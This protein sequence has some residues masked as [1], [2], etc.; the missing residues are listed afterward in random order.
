MNEPPSRK[1]ILP[2][3]SRRDLHPENVAYVEALYAQYH[4]D[5]TLIPAPWVDYFAAIEQSTAE[6]SVTPGGG[7]TPCTS[8]DLQLERLQVRVLQY[9]NSY[10]FLG[11]FGAYLDPLGRVKPELP[12]ELTR[13]YHQLDRVSSSQLFDPGSLHA[14]KP[15]NLDQIEAILRD[16]YCACIGPE[17]MHLTSTTEK[18]WIQQRL[19]SARGHFGFDRATRLHILER[20]TAA[21]G[22]ERYLHTRYVGQKRFSL[23]GAESLIPLLNALVQRGGSRGLREIVLG[24]AH[25]GRLNVQVNLFGKSLQEL[26][27]EF[28]GRHSHTRGT[29]DVKYHL[30]LS[31]DVDTRGGRVH[32][33]LAFN[34]SHLE[35]VAPVVV[36]SVR[37]RQVRA[38]DRQGL[39]ILPVVVHGDAAFA[40]Q[41]VVMETLNMSQTR[42][43]STKGTVHIVVNNQ[44]GFTTSTLKDAR[45]THYS[46]DVAKM[47]SAPIFHVNA[48]DPEAVV[49]IT[50]IA[51][52]YRMR[53]AKDVVIDL[54]CYRRHG[55]NE[56]DEPA[57][58]QPMMYRRIRALP[59]TRERYA[60]RLIQEGVIDSDAVK[61][62]Q[63][64]YRESLESG[65]PLVPGLAI[66]ETS[67]KERRTN[68]SQFE[69]TSWD[70]SLETGVEESRLGHLLQRLNALPEGFTVHPRVRRILEG[71]AAMAEAKQPLD[72]GAAETLAYA[73]LI[74]EG[75]RVRL[76]G[77]DSGRG[78][79]FHRH[80]VLHDQETGEAHV[81]LRQLD[82]DA[83]RFLVTDSLL[84]EEAVLAFEY[85]YA[86]AAPD[87]LV[88]WEAQF[89]DFVNGAQVVIDQFISSGEQ[90]WN[91]L[92]GL[93]MLLPHGYE[94]QG[95]EHSSARPERFLQ[96][97]AQENMQVC[98]PTTP[99][100]IFHLLRR[101]HLRPYRKPLVVMTPKS[102]LRHKLAVSTL[103][104]LGSGTR[105]MEIL[106][107]HEV[108]APE[109][110]K[111]L[112][113]TTGR[114]YFDLLEEKRQNARTDVALVRLEQCYPFPGES[115][116][117][118]LERYT[119]LEELVWAQ[120][121]PENQ[122][123]LA[124]VE[125]RLKGCLDERTLPFFAIARPA[126]AAPAVGY[127]EVHKAQLL[128]LIRRSFGILGPRDQRRSFD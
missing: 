58:T 109:N 35:I 106:D 6:R 8:A 121:E 81:P 52:D 15:S 105:F 123:Y 63:E 80:A 13:A 4:S 24:M 47:V 107:D 78:T 119:A 20:L 57:A 92:C 70:H 7:D 101:Q 115:V 108:T 95:P 67:G 96:L 30:G 74:Q 51:L 11:H 125:P 59:T 94:G 5:P 97:C 31:A 118:L 110:V 19:E 18:R 26:A 39:E 111:R 69:N 104:E 90:K 2:S 40:G 10:R 76:S 91:R 73:T 79:F 128:E 34:P 62:L 22:L 36:G 48:D 45:S 21:E 43:F 112:I 29:G 83:Q 124:F 87:A 93:V 68:W 116:R 49:F 38:K 65:A 54:V 82:P 120:D 17:F 113:M 25:R 77:Q 126:A 98:V 122:G 60:E 32:L 71:R 16:T 27:G 56:A 75:H 114:L 102:L 14:P 55:H 12:E 3:L 28:E 85:G 84:S 33:A 50:Q 53:F 42:G 88:L 72:W 100:Q 86:T 64:R 103:A 37:A 1:R 9:I 44:I 89:G 46:T 127:P 23:E 61:Q 41:G 66:P 117:A 99:A